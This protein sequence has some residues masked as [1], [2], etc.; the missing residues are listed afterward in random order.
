MYDSIIRSMPW[1]WKWLLPQY[2][3]RQRRRLW[4]NP[5]AEEAE[6]KIYR[7]PPPGNGNPKQTNITDFF[8]RMQISDES[9]DIQRDAG[10]QIQ[11]TETEQIFSQQ[12]TRTEL[13]I[14]Q[15][16]ACSMSEEKR[17]QLEYLTDK[18]K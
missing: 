1:H 10:Q 6:D 4:S 2:T 9:E 12:R 14:L 5:R 13:R 11:N 18:N 3:R 16:N 15:W 8:T 7:I 17:K